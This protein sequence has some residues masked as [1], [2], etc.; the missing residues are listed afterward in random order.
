M[1]IISTRAHGALDYL[2][3]LLL[4][5]LPWILN[6]TD[7][8]VPALVFVISGIVTL[9]Y[10]VFTAYELGVTPLISMKA[11]LLLDALSGIFLTISPWIFNFSETVYL[12][13]VIAGLTELL[14]VALTDTSLQP[15]H[16]RMQKI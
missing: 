2:V 6:I 11:H 3:A 12:P 5:A 9:F 8:R 13:F 4:I 7:Y 14:V 15:A 1:K 10:S 16:K